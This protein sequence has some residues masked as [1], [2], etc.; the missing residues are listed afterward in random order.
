M[1]GCL[2]NVLVLDGA[3][4][5]TTRCLRTAYDRAGLRGKL[6]VHVANHDRA[7]HDGLAG[8]T[9]EHGAPMVDE[10]FLGK[11]GTYL[12]NMFRDK[13]PVAF[14]AVWLDFC[15]GINGC[16]V[17]SSQPGSVYSNPREDIRKVLEYSLAREA[18]FGITLA[19]RDPTPGA[20]HRRRTGELTAQEQFLREYPETAESMCWRLHDAH[21]HRQQRVKSIFAR[22]VARF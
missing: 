21:V 12:S 22:H 11:V 7:A 18:Y 10:L 1:F 6:R 20:A 5:C 17:L 16:Q 13:C 15:G 3:H 8:M 4:A 9:R 14:D 19:N 2:V